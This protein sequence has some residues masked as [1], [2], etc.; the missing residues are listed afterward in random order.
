MPTNRIPNLGHFFFFLALTVFAF[1]AS[2]AAV[3]A[4][5]HGT[6]VMQALSDQRLQTIASLMTYVFALVLAFF[7]MPV[8]WHRPFCRGARMELGEIRAGGWQPWG[9]GWDLRR[10]G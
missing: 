4:V 1:L 2:E 5:S 7:A 8:F 9:W 6:P 3:L 10:R